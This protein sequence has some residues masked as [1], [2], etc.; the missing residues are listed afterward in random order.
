LYTTLV[1]PKL[2]YACVAWDSIT[3]TDLSKLERVQSYS[4][5][6]GIAI[7]VKVYLLDWISKHI[8]AGS[9]I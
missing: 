3:S 8:I 7:I 1:W 4:R 9:G 6:V 5:F 2:Q